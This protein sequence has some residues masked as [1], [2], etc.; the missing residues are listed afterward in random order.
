MM[1]DCR[2]GTEA[3]RPTWPPYMAALRGFLRRDVMFEL[4]VSETRREAATEDSQWA[5]AT[6]LTRTRSFVGE[7]TEGCRSWPEGGRPSG[8]KSPLT[9]PTQNTPSHT[10][11]R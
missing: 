7:V 6:D 1:E 3:G 10:Q 4:P 9:S 11:L 8:F 2:R 5:P